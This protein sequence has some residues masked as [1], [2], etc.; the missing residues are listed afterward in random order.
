MVDAREIFMRESDALT[1]RM[2]KDPVLRST[3]VSIAWL[4]G[5]PD[6]DHMVERLDRATRAVPSFRKVV[7][8]PP[9][10]LAAPRWLAA[11]DFDLSWHVRRIDAPA[12]HTPDTVME[13]A[14][15]AAMTAFDPARPLWEFTLIENL[16]GGRAALL[17]KV[18]HAL[19]D[20]VGGM[21][22]APLLFDM[23]QGAAPPAD[24]PAAEHGE[25]L[26][27]ADLVRES[28]AHQAARLARLAGHQTRTAPSAALRTVRHPLRTAAD[29]LATAGSVTRTVA[30]VTRTL[31]PLMT[32]RGLGRHLD[33]LTVPLSDLRS[34]AA[35]GEGTVNDAFIAAVTGGLARYHQRHG[36]AVHELRVTMPISIRTAAD[37]IGGNRITLQRVTVP[38]G[39]GETGERLGAI[40]ARC[41]AARRERSL[42]H[43][44]TI[45]GGLNVLP[46]GVVGG[47]LRHVDVVASNV[48]A[49][50]WP[51]HLAGAPV[52]GLFAWGPTIGAALNVTLL[53]YNGTCGIGVNVDTAAVPDPGALAAC[54][55]EGLGD[56][57]AL[58]GPSAQA[59][60]PLPAGTF[61]GEQAG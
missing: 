60:R 4:A 24:L 15:T 34:A 58:A 1:W 6:W 49:F 12:P 43:T 16:A 22:M 13:L 14:R 47:I 54:L 52:A 8:E 30:P 50:P 53:S 25:R 5:T 17:M 9:G 29:V 21:E 36:E 10:R 32:E 33:M 2:E 11:P 51:V 3:I 38:V 45:A 41:R 42:P 44:N 39:V 61:P 48:P 7:V 35:V 28:L 18:H 46:A 59:T 56:V 23:E 40:G 55:Q 20:G 27:R 31:S 19:T 57:L 26:S 37:P